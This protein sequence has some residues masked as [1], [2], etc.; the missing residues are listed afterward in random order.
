MNPSPPPF[1]GPSAP[2]EE[3]PRKSLPLAVGLTLLFGPLGLFYVNPLGAVLM[4][5]VAFTAGLFT[6]GIAL[7]VVWP[8]CVIWALVATLHIEEPTT[9]EPM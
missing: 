2:P 1:P 9:G 7:F 5:I 4:S 8:V 3:P 6:V